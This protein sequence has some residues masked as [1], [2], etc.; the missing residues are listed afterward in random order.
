MPYA[1]FAAWQR[2]L[3]D[4]PQMAAELEY[5]REA[6]RSAPSLLELPTDFVRPA[7]PSYRGAWAS[8]VFPVKLLGRLQ[9][10][11][12][13][14]NATLYMVLLAAFGTL[15][16]RYTRQEDL[17]IG[18]PVAGRQQTET[19]SMVGLFVNSLIVRSRIQP[20]MPFSALVEQLRDTVLDAMNHQ[21]VP[22]EKLVAELQPER[23]AGIAPLF[24]VMFNLQNREQ[25]QVPFAGLKTEPV[26]VESGTAKFDLNVLMEDRTDGL[27]AWFE[28]STDLFRHESITRMLDHYRLLLESIADDP[29]QPLGQLTLLN[30][31]QRHQILNDWNQTHV[32][33]PADETLVS[34]FEAQ[35]A[36]TP[37]AP[38]L[39]FGELTLTYAE[40]N[41]RANQLAHFLNSL[42]VRAESLIGLCMERSVD[43][44][45]GLY[46]I[47]KAGAAYVP[48]DPEFPQ[49]RLQ[50]MLQDARV[51][52]VLCQSQLTARLPAHSA[53]TIKL[54]IGWDAIAIAN[55][56]RSNPRLMAK[57]ESAA[58]VIYTSGSTGRPKGV[59]NEHRG[60][61]NRLLWMQDR[62]GLTADDRVLQKTPFSFDVSVWEF[63]WPLQTGASLVLA[64]PGGH[65]DARYLANL[66]REQA[67]T[68]LHFVPSMLRA[69]LDEPETTGCTGLRQVFCSGE[70]LAA[71]LCER[72]FASFDAE[73]HNL[74][75]PTEAAIDVSYWQCQ[76]DNQGATIPIG[77]PVA[78][79]QIYIVDDHGALLPAGLPGELWIGGVQVGRGY[80][81]RPELTA[82]RFIAD[83]FSEQSGARVYRTGDLARFRSDGVVEFLGRTDFQI[84]LRGFRIEPGEI[85][86][87][88]RRCEGILQAAV[89]MREDTPGD[90]RLVAYVV[91]ESVPDTTALRAQLSLQ[92]PDY[93]IPT[94]FVPLDDLPL[95]SSGK[96]DRNALPAPDWSDHQRQEYAPPRTTVETVLC[97]I[98]GD[99]LNVERVGIH[100]NFF[101]LGGHSLLAT[102]VVARIRD[103]LGRQLQLKTLFDH[104]VIAHLAPLLEDGPAGGAISAIEP[105]AEGTD[106]PLSAAQQRLWILDQ[107]EPG[108]P[109]YNIPWALRLTGELNPV[110]L[111]SAL[112]ELVARHESLRTR[113]ATV[114][115]QPRQA[116]LQ[117]LHLPLQQRQLASDETQL[118]HE[119][120]RLTR[121]PFSLEQGPL[122]VATLLQRTPTEHV[123]H[124]VMHHI[125][126]DAW[127]TGVLLRELSVLYNAALNKSPPD[128]PVLPVQFGDYAVWEQ[129]RLN[130]AELAETVAY[131]KAQLAAAPARLDLPTD[132]PR[133]AVQTHNGAWHEMRLS[134]A[135]TAKL[136]RLANDRSATLYMVLLA[137]FDVL[138]ARYSNQDD[139]VVGTPVA[140]RQHTELEHLIGFFINTLAIRARIDGDELF[141]QLLEQVKQT[142]LDA[143]AHQELPFER[144]VEELQPPRDTS[145]APVFQVMFIVQNAPHADLQL[146]GLECEQLLFEF[147]SAKL[148][149]TLSMQEQNGELVGYFEYN[150]DLFRTDTIARMG[151]HFGRLLEQI[152][153][154][155]DTRIADLQL[156]GKDERKQLLEDW[157]ATAR[158]YPQRSLHALYSE[159]AAASP[160]NTAVECGTERLSYLELEQRA[161]QL[162]H[163]L[164]TLGAG[165]DVP[166]A[167]CLDRSPDM[168]VA[169]L[170]VLKAGSA[171]VPLDPDFPADRLRYMLEDCGAPVLVTQQ[172]H[173][174]LATGL[175][176]S[177]ICMDD[178]DQ[179]R[180]WP[181]HDPAAAVTPDQLAYIIYTSGSTGQPKGVAIE[182]RAVVNFLTSMQQQPGIGPAER[183]LA[184]T[185]LSFDISILEIFGPLLSGATVVL[186]TRAETVDGFALVRLLERAA[187]TLMQATPATWRMLLQTGWRGNQGLRLLCGGEALDPE[188]ARQLAKCG[189]E[190]WNMYGPTETTV[191]S[192]CEKIEPDQSPGVGRP[193]A[194]TRCYVLDADLNPVPL[195][196]AGELWIAGDGVARGYFNRPDLT[197]GRFIADPFVQASQARMYRTG[198][199]ARFSADGRLHVLGRTDNQV[200]LRGF[201]IELGEIEAAIDALP[202]ITQCVTLLRE[203][204]PGDQRLVA[205]VT[206]D[207]K[208]PESDTLRAAL[209]KRLP[210]YM[211]PAL[212]MRL[213]QF[214][215]TPNGKVDRK[216][217]PRPEWQSAQAYVAPGS[218]TETA[219]AAIWS[220]ILGVERIGIHDDFFVLGGHSLLATRMIAR[221]VD[222]LAVQVPLMTL[223]NHP[224]IA[225][226]AAAVARQ[227]PDKVQSIQKLPRDQPL[228]LSYAQQRLWFLDELSPGDPMYN[229]PWVMSLQGTPDAGA[230]QAAIAGLVKRHEAFRTAFPNQGGEA[231]QLIH[232]DMEITLR[233]EDLRNAEA[234]AIQQ[235]LTELA[236]QRMNLATGPLAW[237]TLLQIQD[238]EF[239]LVLTVHHIVFD[240]WSHGILLRELAA[241]YNSALT[242]SSLH[243]E[244]LQL[245]FADYAGWQ[246]EWYGSEDFQHQLTYWKNK[247][248][249]AP[250]VL[251][252]PTDKPR[253]PVQTSNG[254]NISRM[255]PP[256][257]HAGVKAL[258]EREGVSLF[259]LLLATFNILMARYSGQQ[260]L[261]VGTPVSGRNRT[262][263]EKIIGFFL[264]TLVIRAE[265]DGNPSFREFLAQTRQTVL[266]AFAHQEL[267]FE[268][269]VEALQ[270]ERDTSRHPLFQVHFVLQHVDIDWA[271]FDGLK[272]APVE[273][274]F[275]TAKFDIMFFVFEANNSLSVRL[276]YNTDLFEAATIDRMIDH[277]ATLLGGI[278][279][280]PDTSVGELPLLPEQEATTLLVNWNRTDFSYPAL[281]TMHGLFEAQVLQQPNA[282]ALLA[283][284]V[285]YSYRELNRRA[286]KLATQL[287]ALS[288]GPEVLVALYSERNAEL[289]VGMLAIQKAGGAYVPVDPDYPPQR[290]AHMLDD[291][292]APVLLT[293]SKLVDRLPA[294][295]AHV[296]C[297]DSCD[298]TTNT[299][300]D[301]N[302]VSGVSA[303][304]LG[305]VIYT[306]GSTGLPKGVE[307][308]HRNAVALIAWAGD[309]FTPAEFAGVLAATSVCFDLSVFEI[310][311]PLALGGRIILVRDALA[312]PELNAGAGVTLINTVPSAMAELVRIRGVPASVKTVNL[313]GEP[314][315]TALVNSIYE[316]GS[317]ERV[318]D[319]YGPS[320]DTTYST[321]TVR[322]RN[323]A[324]SIGRP[325]HNT[326]AYV[327]D[328][329]GKAVP[330]GVPGELYLGGAGVTRGY[331]N[332]PDLTAQRYL[333]NPFST[334]AGARM[335][336]TGD[337]VRYRAD[338]RLEFIGR[339]DHQVK[340][341]GFRIELGEIET[342]LASHPAVEN[343]VVMA[344]EDRPG[345]K[346]LVAYIVASTQGLAGQELERWEQEQVSQ[347]QDLWQD[348]YSQPQDASDPAYDFKG[349]NSSYTGDAIPLAEM[350]DWLANAAANISLLQPQRVLEIGSGTGLIVGQIAP[351]VRAYT[352]TDF[353]AAAIT[354]LE[355]LRT[356]LEL[357]NLELRQCTADSIGDF[358]AGT[359]DTI[360]LN[361]VAQYFPD[362]DYL[363]KFIR[364]A[365][366][367]LDADGHIFL[368]DLRNARLLETY[369]TSVQLYQAEA[370][371]ELPELAAAIRRRTEQEE[372]LLL[373]PALFVALQNEI[374]AIT[375]V[376]VAIK[377][378][379]HRNELSRYRYDVT[380]Q[381]NGAAEDV[382]V[383]THMDWN[384]ADL[385]LEQ[386]A[387]IL[388]TTGNSGLLL[389]AI[390]DARLSQDIFA[391]QQLLNAETGT[392]EELRQQTATLD[393]G[394]EPDDLYALAARKG[395]DLQLA[396]V[397]P[398]QITALFRRTLQPGF[399]ASLMYSTR[400]V[401]WRDYGNDPLQGKL[402]RSLVPILR[403]RLATAV[404]EYMMPSAF[405]IMESFPLTPNG[406][407][408]RKALPAPER[409]RGD[410]EIYVAPR[411][412][413]EEQLVAIWSQVLG[414]R[415]IGVHDDFFAL[416]GHSLLA[417]QLVS[418]IRDTLKTELPLL[419]LFNHPTV[420][421]LAIEITGEH[422]AAATAAIH[423]C[424]RSA[425]LPLSFA[426]QRLWFLDQLDGINSAYNVPLALRLEGRLDIGALQQA[427]NDLIARHESLRTRFVSTQGKPL[428]VVAPLLEISIDIVNLPDAP[429]GQLLARLETLA[430]APF[431]LDQDSLLRVHVLRA[432]ER[433]CLLLLVMHH[434][435]SDGW[436]LGIFA[437]ELAALYAGHCNGQTV[438]LPEL[439]V[440]Y[441]DFAVW[442][443]NWF[444][445]EELQRQL[446]YWQ[447]QLED[448][449]A[450]LPLL[451]DKPRPPVQS[452]RGAHLNR[453]LGLTIGPQLRT[454]AAAEDCTLFMLLLAAYQV[455][456]SRYS[457]TDDIVV[458]TPI[459]G[460][461]RT[462]IESLIGFFVNTLAMRTD[463]SGDPDFLTALNRVRK[464]ALGAYGHQEMPFEKLVEELQPDRD[465]SHP[466]IFQT[467]FVLQ[468]NLSDD[469]EFQGLQAT[470]IDF[471]L[472]SAKFDLSLFMVEFND[473]LT[474]SIEYNTDLFTAATIERLLGH[475][476][477]L[478]HSIAANPCRAI[479]RLPLLGTDERQQVLVEFNASTM[480][481]SPQRVHSLVE[482]QAAATPD[483][484]AL[485]CGA[486]ELTYAELNRRANRLA[487][488]LGAAG[489]AP[490]MLVAICANRGI[491]TATGVLAVL[492]AGAAYVPIDP[493]YPRERVAYMLEDC[494][495]ATLLS[496]SALLDQLPP[497]HCPTVCL[498][499]FDWNSGDGKDL[500]STA[501]ELVYVIYTSGSTGKPKGVE[502]GHAGLSNLIQ[503]QS[504]QPGLKQ[505]AR[506]LQYA[507]LSFDVSFQ[508]LFSTWAQGGTV[509]LIS[510]ELRRDFPA[511]A[512]FIASEQIERIYLPFAALQPLAETLTTHHYGDC[513]LKDVVI[514]GE[515]LQITPAIRDM[516][517]GLPDARLHNQYGP[518]ETHVVTAY[519]L[520][521]PPEKWMRLPSIGKPVANT[522]VYV[523]DDNREPVPVGVPGE[524]Y[525]SGVQVA[526][527]YIHRKALTAERFP[528]D[529]F[530]TPGHA[531]AHSRMY[532]TG[533]RVRFLADGNL[534][535]LGRTDDQFKWR[536]FRIEPGEIETAL[537][538]RTDVHQATVILRE[539]SPGDK[540]L[541]AYIVGNPD[542]A[543]EAAD[544]RS[545]LRE[546]VPDYMVPSA[547][548]ILKAMPLTPSGKVARRQL[549][550]PDYSDTAERLY[551]PPRTP[552]EETLTRVWAD[553]LGIPQA[554][555]HDDFFELGGHS[556]LATQL[557]ARVRD[558]LEI[559]LP[560]ITL[561]NHPTVAQFAVDA[562]RAA[563]QEVPEAIAPALRAEAMPLS[564][565]QQRLWF[566]DQLEPG[567]PVY[568][569]P[570]AMRLAGP[571]NL[572]AL[573]AAINDLVRRHETL[574]TVFTSTLGKP[575]QRVLSEARTPIEFDDLSDA[576][577]ADLEQILYRLSRK[578][579]R[580]SELPLFRAHV[581]RTAEDQHILLLV[582]HHIIADGWSL[583][584]LFRELTTLYSGHCRGKAAALPKLPIQYADYAVWQQQWASG[585][586][587]Q[588]QMD[589]WAHQLRGAPALLELPTD[590]PRGATQTYNGAFVE[591]VLPQAVHTG[592]KAIAYAE[593]STLFMVCLT[594]FNILLSRYSGQ[595]DIC[596]GTPIAGRRQSEVENLIGFFINTLVMRN[597]LEGNPDFRELLARV[598]RTAL[599]AF[600]HQELPFEKLVDELHPVRDMSHAPLFQVA[601]IL[602][603]TPWDSS[604]KLVDLDIEPIELDY[605][606]AKFDLSLVMAERQEGL[607]VHFEYN[608]DL[609]DQPTM[610]RMSGS[611]ETLLRAI[612]SGTSA[613]ISALPLLTA[614]ERQQLLYDWNKTAT[615]YADAHCIHTLLE[616]RCQKQP[617]APAI[618]F[619][620]QVISYAEM[621][622]LANQLAHYLIARGAGPGTI[623]G[624]CLERS[625]AL[626]TS[627]LAVFKA[628]A[629]YVPLDPNYPA[630]RLEWMLHDSRAPLL[631]TQQAVLD[632]L[633]SHAAIAVN[634]DIEQNAIAECSAANPALRASPDDLAYVIYTSGSTGKPKGVMIPHRGVCNL[635]EAQSQVFCLGPQDRMLQFA[636]ISFDAS[637]FE[638]IMGLHAGAAM[639]M[640]S[641]DDLLPGAP[642]LHVLEQHKVT[643]VTLPPTALSQLSPTRLPHLHTITVAGEACPPELVS[644]W[645][646][647]R[648]FFN[649]Y[650]PTETTVWA[651]YTR[652][653]PGEP[654]TIGKPIINARLYILDEHLQPVPVGVPGELCIG[655]A[656]LARGYLNQAELTAAKFRQDPFVDTPDAR[657]YLS[658]DRV[659]FLANGNIEF[660]GRIDQQLKVRGFRIEPGEIENALTARD[661]VRDAIVVARGGDQTARQLIAYIVSQDGAELSLTDLRKHLKQSLPDYMVPAA[662]VQLEQFPLTPNGKIDRDALPEPDDNRMTLAT[663]YVAPRTAAER[664]LA[665]IWSEL[666]HIEQVGIH[667]NFFELGGD[668]ILSIQ[669]I[670]RAAQHQLQ[671][672]PKQ[673][674]QHQTI[675]EIAAVANESKRVLTE[676]GA[677]AGVVLLTPIQHWFTERNTDY[678][679]HFNQSQLFE[680]G[681]QLDPGALERAFHKVAEHH[682]ALRIR[683]WQKNGTWHQEQT[684]GAVGQIVRLVRLEGL[685]ESE[686]ARYT[687]GLS[688]ALQASFDLKKGPLVR[689]LLFRRGGRNPDQLLISAHHMVIDWVSWAILLED[690]QLAYVAAKNNTPLRLPLKTSSYRS[691]AEALQG[692]ANTDALQQELSWWLE[693]PWENVV[694]IG[695]DMD[696]TDGNNSE[697]STRDVTV[698]LTEEET[699]QLLRELPRRWH[700]RIND[701]LLTAAGRACAKR[702]GADTILID[703]EAHG[704]EPLFD[705]LD[706]S[707]TIGWFTSLYPVLLQ[708]NPAD[709]PGTSLQAIQSQLRNI[710]VNGISFGVL[711]YLAGSRS[712]REAMAGIPRPQI[713]FNYFGQLD[714]VAGSNGLLRPCFAPRGREQS[715][716]AQRPHLFD[717]AIASVEGRMQVSVLYSENLHSRDTADQF[718]QSI[719]SELR[720]LLSHC[721]SH[722]RQTFRPADFPLAA[723]QQQ[724]LDRLLAGQP[725]DDIYRLTP[726]QHG[727]LFHSLMTPGNDVY[728]ARFR[729]RLAGAIDADLF[730]RAW[731][732]VI[733]R[734]TSLRSSFHWQELSEPVQVVHNDV[735][736]QM[737]RED[738]SD[739]DEQLQASK[740]HAWLKADQATP[741]D[742]G[743]APLLRL[744]LI[745]LGPD[746]HQFIWSFHHAI[747]DGWSVPLVLKE[748]FNCYTAYQAG[749]T[750]QLSRAQ[751][752]RTYIEWLA[753]QDHAAAK[754]FWRNNLAGFSEPT[755]LPGAHLQQLPA[756]TLPDFAELQLQIDASK[757]IQ[758]RQ[759]AQQSRLTLNTLVQGV[760]A[761]LL[762]RYSGEQDVLFGAT[763]S[764]RPANLPGVASMVGLFLNTLPVRA[765][766]DADMPVI[767]WLQSLQATQL[768]MRQ[769]EFVSLVEI[770]GNSDI[771]R[772]RPM[773]GSLL[774]FENYPDMETMWAS[775]DSI[776]IREVDGFDRTNY[777]LTVNVAVF[778]FMHVRIVFARQMFATAAIERLSQ[779]FRTL[780]DAIV[781]NPQARL[782][783]LSLLQPSEELY[784]LEELNRTT[785]NYPADATLPALFEQQVAKTPYAVA[786]QY[787]DISL[788][789][790][791]FN[792]RVNQLAHWL[793]AAGVR[794]D[795]MVGVCMERSVEL[796]VALYAIQKAGGAY[797]PLDPEYPEQ[798]LNHILEDAA[799]SIVLIHNV[800]KTTMAAL[801]AR[802][803]NIDELAGDISQQP[804]HNP[805]LRARATHLAYV[806]F[807]SGSTGRP[808]GVMNEHRGI[809]NRLLWMQ[810]E[811]SLD[812]SDRV[813]QKTPFSFD[814]SVWEFFWPLLTG[815]RL[816][817]ARPGGHRDSDYLAAIIREQSITTLHFVPSM[818]QVFLQHP[819]VQNSTSLRRVICSGEALP[820]ELQQRFFASIDAELHNLYGP[821][822]AAVDV[823]YWACRRDSRDNVVPIGRPVANTRIYIVEPNGTPAPIGVAGELWIGG[824]QVARGYSNQPGLTRERFIADPFS[825]QPDARVYRTGDLAR[826]RSDGVIEFLGRIDQQLK[827]RGFRIE[828]GEIEA[829]LDAL[830]G[831]SQSLVVL[832][833]DT[834]G[835]KRLVGYVCGSAGTIPDA[836]ALLSELRQHLPDYM[837]PS[838]CMVLTAFPLLPSGKID[839]QALP[840]PD[841]H[842]DQ[843]YVPPR[844]ETETALAH[845]WSEALSVERVGI[846]DDFFALGGHSLVAMKLVSRIMQQLQVDLPLDRFLASPTIAAIADTLAAAPGSS[847]QTAIKPIE[848]AA[849]RRQRQQ[850]KDD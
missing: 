446:S 362:V 709:D 688:N 309:V 99:L 520:Q 221:I 438:V 200:K 542:A 458:G 696:T 369:H 180:S 377:R 393:T 794:P 812:A 295:S 747:V 306:S 428:Q 646:T 287:Q 776:T 153:A 349:W 142:A 826:Y 583:G 105:R 173:T 81:N 281:N 557:I 144:L 527:G 697:G 573:Q 629:A 576:G 147:G 539:D 666:L 488:A 135:L 465:T 137:A 770:Q 101:A 219:I 311:C 33:Y 375:G 187:I 404:P 108:N 127:S 128:L 31:A 234:G 750:P 537:A 195:G 650:G 379:R 118:Q 126:G 159:Q 347:W 401:P 179:T 28:Y 501:G 240:A 15:L 223:F 594:A 671:F 811:Y 661:D 63:F 143:Y 416:G 302:P 644:D 17:L 264:H 473:G 687:A 307:I 595:T 571:L 368:G 448:A 800:T 155:P 176:L 456:L 39:I 516:F 203:D 420:A 442:Q 261:L 324:P 23:M 67:V 323:A 684:D 46:G 831:V 350:H 5:W 403:E 86:A 76:R 333:R 608:S 151:Q 424:D 210:D 9:T 760:W 495:A 761:M 337:Q 513:A 21:D 27:A 279:A 779:H 546:R 613:A 722:I 395:L 378:G 254:A 552:L 129:E 737:H 529:P 413:V 648:R 555:I 79:T 725:V 610:A 444:A 171:Y 89:V 260:D 818:L 348:A 270:P 655:G 60:I 290:V 198:D 844:N 289:I 682:D 519:T 84:K 494:K 77:R 162:A 286:N 78:N 652:C 52:L 635:A 192:S 53:R 619:D 715:P 75:G 723:L 822:E 452:F 833:E 80:L 815:A 634:I 678:P 846:N 508:E 615:P 233:A 578:A 90:Q 706:L 392:A 705:Q 716:E 735:P 638:I 683:V 434:I 336:R 710:P 708:L 433:S 91:S 556:L 199:L 334:E 189:S 300:H 575:A 419:T 500:G 73:L 55:F 204:K 511:L 161:N 273:F 623:V 316:L 211:I 522:R 388:D 37:E 559:E 820:A 297:L 786:L 340:L 618:C 344:R 88:L 749:Q 518:S 491:N 496:E 616:Q 343:T 690:L 582:L 22:F 810:D 259:M 640:A 512:A 642:L 637:I 18:T 267:P 493:N 545:W 842:A 530:S 278:I 196:V 727:M 551:V 68:T 625:P 3:L 742:F 841:W 178:A 549:P 251:E 782:G 440:Q 632:N 626:V 445:G 133:P 353:S 284:G 132:Q 817:V 421:G 470:P 447:Q 781:T 486:A 367:L 308:E 503:W 591:S 450:I 232:P 202:G 515:Q 357:A 43:M 497:H 213:E 547:F 431:R 721:L 483:R 568:N 639:V 799:M 59:V 313:A 651:S 466:P 468:E 50:E 36:R 662:F 148:D 288:V 821:T 250:Q 170:G 563:G 587:M 131:W 647:D 163:Q 341:R 686:Q 64:A 838:A 225:G 410:S 54:N 748:V 830:P 57:P 327:L 226:L 718:A 589:Y 772:G 471:E 186:A 561:F 504:Q 769:Y 481:V 136:K 834:P 712:T 95:T 123:L 130:S 848:R 146:S 514:A 457:A 156:L 48:L 477:N 840:S 100:D 813:L 296:I 402:Q 58:Y 93:M 317:V 631:V 596:I 365:A 734:N 252:L 26:I 184:V 386:L 714:Q 479:S 356:R 248:G 592:L 535:F 796:V 112:D 191:W 521:G 7:T 773:F 172:R 765:A 523:L 406:K 70:A 485:S 47:L 398:G 98:W 461:N 335:Y 217:L 449:P 412:N 247:L 659:R 628:G 139:I 11:A 609:F 238:T 790:G 572:D 802:V 315:S 25:E 201:R 299:Q 777:P 363:I 140:G 564:F 371:Q 364:D 806:I 621:N 604:A 560:L 832:R 603:N 816:I 645:G 216:Q 590:R 711:R 733:A 407:V 536:G 649:L 141:S 239:L 167:I 266:E 215:L 588:S 482:A 190:L 183:L 490:G 331:R 134:S 113:F 56:P 534:E 29:G 624:V 411:S 825:Q 418:R 352:A 525:I 329:F 544:L 391:V 719:A 569:V 194:N 656:G 472:G 121:H 693:Q 212:F 614:T 454:L 437:R 87:T 35:V 492:K 460:R 24:Q 510:E 469:I 338:G 169:L 579:F 459:A 280:N 188:L 694:P 94:A 426:Q 484:I 429:A 358:T 360:I 361:S 703:M 728:F 653:K 845:I 517:S 801:Q 489:V 10:L 157:N 166:V 699:R 373:D 724:E 228:P 41:E 164:L 720:D 427:V 791:E 2:T 627:I 574:R 677:V 346:R 282:T 643:A 310:F 538:A 464:T 383:P 177:A 269:L 692:L 370:T 272:A 669:I 593:R 843:E 789:Y 767:E 827:L 738:W 553:V 283:D 680:C 570:W 784:L 342:A 160:G 602:Q 441:P 499:Q 218:A 612:V 562:A 607:L 803:F 103:T 673:L 415:Q 258:I 292:G 679:Q 256:A 425:P 366:K 42:G 597:K 814:V 668:S 374:P 206:T 554:G 480:E 372:E 83:P 701:V 665:E 487:R 691:W 30:K 700:T 106:A 158:D 197:A 567:N 205:Y 255:L 13:D 417:T 301:S 19:E 51:G 382:T 532:R 168:V 805:E 558:A 766:V 768:E 828:P 6:L 729:W 242:G 82:E 611:F 531:G 550:A 829:V 739:V 543:P 152:A 62:Y 780:L 804:A 581:I 8:A 435:V 125:I 475:L 850:P 65:R 107:L 787:A 271:M 85:E 585:A 788:S 713:G 577:Q 305:Y 502:L 599:E 224:T 114:G 345:D 598:R 408:N 396:G 389:T 759:L 61:C 138:L 509:V 657:I 837:V 414:V 165:K 385:D 698:W 96:L 507:S 462:E 312:L 819:G 835:D 809:C 409:K 268:T 793:I 660:L 736:L 430:Q 182:H 453:N 689:A 236:Q 685:P 231:I 122:L 443:R 636:S 12:Q 207:G 40:L 566:L 285:D 230:L 376:R 436:S 423:P 741:F 319:L 505:P 193:V 291:S 220:E 214:P 726:L 149:L 92:L 731:Q 253:P 605:G 325:V 120:T 764:G 586:G 476:D 674:F 298:W 600:A 119:L 145:Y 262:E 439:T 97:E 676:Q 506:T 45:V 740:L 849:R 111:Q 663:E 14:H 422:A 4:G 384:T 124:L 526:R 265:L 762:S 756:D 229:I 314:L 20:D 244:P 732:T 381:I 328:A 717:I 783:S 208:E 263:L 397:L 744:A 451:T 294:H 321:W 104:P 847:R 533:D 580:L 601:F 757:I 355:T 707:R 245:E 641:R 16:W 824:V 332:R 743:R 175:P 745:R 540:R 455:L 664:I 670:A 751:P 387:D 798:R 630:D 775:T 330:I 622:R 606:V 243:L 667:D 478:L 672:S 467:L 237:F 474:A 839:R 771:P 227:N 274:E 1:A 524:L 44:V 675:A 49:E 746:D 498:D 752:F 32:S 277:F 320:E 339:L 565:A 755:P 405:V 235:R 34:L 303:A 795:I 394:V 808:K 246:R 758:L 528:E 681:E 102:R 241:F 778:D 222:K 704:R 326:Q 463:L 74:Y 110:A 702:T 695:V 249:D 753:D 633:P 432:D 69:F 72:F 390:P 351:T 548:V 658:G 617:D 318:N 275:G 322:E 584:V 185:T 792:D 115:G 754:S 293:Q 763:S 730:L 109:V 38:A 257:L 797:V 71:D 785:V 836:T 276:E 150:T 354:T 66:I 359:F 117:Q 399:D 654:V 116:V 823:T 380:L 400:A 774:A 620:E 154:Q 174:G 209:Q 181:D 807:T 541:V 304:N